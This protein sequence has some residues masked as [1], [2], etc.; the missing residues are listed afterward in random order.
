MMHKRQ[1]YNQYFLHVVLFTFSSLF[2]CP[3]DCFSQQLMPFYAK[4]GKWGYKTK[5]GG[6]IIIKP[7]LDS[8]ESFLSSEGYAKV[9]IGKKVGLID[10]KGKFIIPIKYQSIKKL[11]PG[12]NLSDLI[13]EKKGLFALFSYNG[14]RITKFIYE[15]IVSGDYENN[16][17]LAKKE[18]KFGFFSKYTGKILI[19]FVYEE[20]TIFQQSRS[21]VKK[22]GK[23]FVIDKWGDD[24]HKNSIGEF[25]IVTSSE[26]AMPKKGIASF[27]KYIFQ[28]LQYPDKAKKKN[29]EGRVSVQFIVEKDGSLSNIKVIKGI[30]PECDAEV[31]RLFKNSPKWIPAQKNGEPKRFRASYPVNF[32]LN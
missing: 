27:E 31:V 23:S 19:P 29:I 25:Y 6:K 13:V 12:V 18:G 22:E 3:L 5:Q 9:S 14:R 8:V 20:A 21:N 11:I 24:P 17:V 26:K 30:D 16:R 4:N 15:Q 10:H 1:T 32:S 28:N 7:K 2:F